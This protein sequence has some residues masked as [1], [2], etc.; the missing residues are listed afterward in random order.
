MNQ[1]RQ[2][3]VSAL[4]VP[5]TFIAILAAI[6]LVWLTLSVFGNLLN[7]LGHLLTGF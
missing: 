7:L 6:G 2:K 5:I 4:F 1:E 3:A